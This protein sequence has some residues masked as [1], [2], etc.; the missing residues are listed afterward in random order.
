V[1]EVPKTCFKGIFAKDLGDIMYGFGDST[2][3]PVPETLDAVEAIAVD[4]VRELI[5]K[6]LHNVRFRTTCR[7][8]TIEHYLVMGPFMD[9][10]FSACAYSLTL[11]AFQHSR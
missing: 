1:P 10:A 4:F 9:A 2:D 8:S 5:T 3:H 7:S 6:C 11:I